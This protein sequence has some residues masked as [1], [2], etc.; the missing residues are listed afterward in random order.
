MHESIHAIHD[1]YFGHGGSRSAPEHFCTSSNSAGLPGPACKKRPAHIPFKIH[2]KC[3][4]SSPS[5]CFSSEMHCVCVC[6]CVARYFMLKCDVIQCS[7]KRTLS[8]YAFGDWVGSQ[9]TYIRVSN[10][11]ISLKVTFSNGLITQTQETRELLV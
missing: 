9:N 11:M 4:R 7:R 1:N 2:P 10:T 6:V 5:C 3:P 8:T